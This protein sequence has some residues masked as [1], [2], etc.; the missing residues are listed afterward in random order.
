MTGEDMKAWLES[1]ES[2]QSE[3]ER[4]DG[5]AVIWRGVPALPHFAFESQRAYVLTRLDLLNKMAEA[6]YHRTLRELL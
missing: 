6:S 1:D 4:R 5:K 2:M 3:H